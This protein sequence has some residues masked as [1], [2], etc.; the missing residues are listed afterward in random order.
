[1][2]C[3]AD[4]FAFQHA[5][6]LLRVLASAEPYRLG[7]VVRP[8]KCPRCYQPLRKTVEQGRL[9]LYKP[10]PFYFREIVRITNGLRLTMELGGCRAAGTCYAQHSHCL[11]L[12]IVSFALLARQFF[13]H[14]D[15]ANIASMSINIRHVSPSLSSACAVWVASTSDGKPEPYPQFA[16]RSKAVLT[17]TSQRRI[18]HSGIPV[19]ARIHRAYACPVLSVDRIPRKA[20]SSCRQPRIGQPLAADRFDHRI[21]PLKAVTFDVAFVQ[22]GK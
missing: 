16:S 10:A 20:Y 21:Q 22:T 13:W 4:W 18:S 11:F 12:S 5:S 15:L 17:Y 6:D 2:F 3:D 1:M 9:L 14:P 19:R 7:R 8:L